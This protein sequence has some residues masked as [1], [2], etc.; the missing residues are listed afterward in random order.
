MTKYKLPDGPTVAK[1]FL[2]SF[3]MV[4]EPIKVI[5]KNMDDYG[6]TYGVQTGVNKHMIVTQNPSFIEHVL[7]KNHKNYAKSKIVAEKLG[8]FIGNGLLTSNGEYWLRQ[9]RLIQPGFHKQK[10]H[11]LYEVM[12]KTVDGFL[13]DFPVGKEVDFYPMMNKLAFQIVINTLFNIPMPEKIFQELADI[14]SEVQEFIVKDIRQPYKYWWFLISGET[15]KN[16]KKS[17][18][19]REIIREIVR[20]RQ[21]N[22]VRREDLLDMLLDARYDDTGAPMEEEQVL[23]EILILIIAGH[24]TTANALSWAAYLL[25]NHQEVLTDLRTTTKNLSIEEIV[26]HRGLAAIIKETMR[27]YPPAWISDREAIQDD[28]FEGISYPKGTIIVLFLYGVHH[29][30]KYW[31]RPFSFKP[32]RFKDE[33][34]EKV[35]SGIYYPFGAGP[36]FCIGS[37]FAMAEMALFLATFIQNFDIQ[38]TT[39]A[40]NM[41]PLITLRPDKVV[42]KCER[43]VSE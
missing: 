32:E 40:P 8:R 29:Q 35:V 24:E 17:G 28:V 10:I 33:S 42:L 16:F 22:G 6:G 39:Q 21:R 34:P 30:E 36:R 11:N 2:S 37:S 18:R 27:L 12:Q 26:N 14:I 4:K 9:R 1:S 41:I 7:K 19:A 43:V 15:S 5:S 31:E 20:E 3:E 23:D 13:H 38:A 25:A